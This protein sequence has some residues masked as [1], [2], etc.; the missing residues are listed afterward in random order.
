MLKIFTLL[1]SIKEK[2]ETGQQLEVTLQP[3]DE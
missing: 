2:A 3:E 1:I